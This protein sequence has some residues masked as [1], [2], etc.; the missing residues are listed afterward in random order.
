MDYLYSV[1]KTVFECPICYKKHDTERLAD[2]C[3]FDHIKERCIRHDWEWG[4]NLENLSRKYDLYRGLPDELKNVNKDNC[5]KIRYLQSCDE[6]V[7]KISEIKPNGA[8]HVWGM[9]K[10]KSSCNYKVGFNDLKNP[11]PPE[12]F[13]DYSE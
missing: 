10:F 9:N 2:M 12:D 1:E 13:V 8:I 7:Y 3:I 5:F 4:M 6:P 11:L